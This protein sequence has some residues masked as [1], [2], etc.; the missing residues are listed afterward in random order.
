[1][2][3][4]VMHDSSLLLV[5]SRDVSDDRMSQLLIDIRQMGGLADEECSCIFIAAN[6]RTFNWPKCRYEMETFY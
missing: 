5:D 6:N 4:S 3:D 2:H 1:M